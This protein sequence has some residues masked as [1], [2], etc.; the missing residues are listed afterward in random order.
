VCSSDLASRISTA[1]AQAAQALSEPPATTRRAGTIC[2][3]AS[4]PIELVPAMRTAAHAVAAP[5]ELAAG[6]PRVHWTPEPVCLEPLAPELQAVRRKRRA[7]I[8]PRGPT[9]QVVGELIA[10]GALRRS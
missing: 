3:T 5:R 2:E 9:D 8:T 7:E 10:A 4:E 1:A 6:S